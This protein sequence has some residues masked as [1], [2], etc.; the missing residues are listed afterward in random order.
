MK[1]LKLGAMAY[2]GQPVSH[3]DDFAARVIERLDRVDSGRPDVI[4]FPELLT[5]ELFG[6]IEPAAPPVMFDWLSQRTDAYLDLFTGQARRRGRW[7]VG[8]SHVVQLDGRF[9]N[10]AFLFAPDGRIFTQR[11]LHLIPQVESG[12]CTPGETVETVDIGGVVIATLICY[13]VEFPETT[14]LARL[15]GA[16]VIL[17][18]A[19]TIGEAGYWRVRHCAAARAVENTLATVHS[20]LIGETIP[21]YGF[22]GAAAIYGPCD[23]GFPDNGLLAETELNREGDVMAEI[24]LDDLRHCRDNGSVRP[25]RDRRA[26]LLAELVA[27][28]QKSRS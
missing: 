26:D 11:K 1:T 27:L 21:T 10:T 12:L 4:V 22:K 23:K 14:R 6:M 18:P 9:Y 17:V 19:A 16:D 2:R 28:D 25:F 24:D 8:G 20:S 15:K 13:D 7:I 3:F 5:T